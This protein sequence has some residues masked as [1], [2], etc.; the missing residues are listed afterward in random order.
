[1]QAGSLQTAN[2]GD[3]LIDDVLNKRFGAGQA[4][5]GERQSDKNKDYT[6]IAE[7][8]KEIIAEREVR[9]DATLII[10][11]CQPVPGSIG[12]WAT[13]KAMQK[14]IPVRV[15]ASNFDLAQKTFGTD[16]ANLDIFFGDTS[17][18]D[19]LDNALDGARNVVYAD[20]G[21]LPFG[22]NSFEAR[23]KTG[24]ARLLE[25]SARHP[26]PPPVC[27][28]VCVCVCVQ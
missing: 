7:A 5:Y 14:D 20:E 25:V 13:I 10:G 16:G 8:A 1:M 17:D 11:A 23:H 24:L 28:C 4:F 21:T 3:D 6:A 22:P 12:Q 2:F 18:A 27:V 26:P 15:L 19:Q 9:Q